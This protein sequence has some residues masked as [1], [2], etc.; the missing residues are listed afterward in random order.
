MTYFFEQISVLLPAL[1]VEIFAP[2]ELDR[3]VSEKQGLSVV[4]S[5]GDSWGAVDRQSPRSPYE[6]LTGAKAI[7]VMLRDSKFGIEAHGL[8]SNG[9]IMV[10][11]GSKARGVN[12]SVVNIYRS[13]RE[14]LIK[15]GKI[16]PTS[17]ERILEFKSDVL[18]N[19]PSAA[20]AVILDRNDNGRNS[21]KERKSNKTLNEL[22]AEQANLVS[23]P[24]VSREN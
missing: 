12:E 19:S 6:P 11:S 9:E 22:Y 21:W 15:E 18:F 4:P 1:G 16:T 17:D 7:E 13:L 23:Q 14:R 3:R 24:T 20:S 2:K 10:L 5:I 8:E